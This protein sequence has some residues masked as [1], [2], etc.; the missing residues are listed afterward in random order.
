MQRHGGVTTRA[1]QEPQ[2]ED[3][4]VAATLDGLVAGVVRDVI[5]LV[6]LEEVAGVGGV[7]RLQQ[8]LE[9][10]ERRGGE[11]RGRRKRKGGGGKE[12]G[13]KGERGEKEK[14]VEKG[15]RISD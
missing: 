12:K 5:V 3:V 10:E 4:V 13:G 8:V 11:E 7:A 9:R 15:W 14:G 6:L 1:P 2:L